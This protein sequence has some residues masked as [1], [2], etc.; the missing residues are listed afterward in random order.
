MDDD[1]RETTRVQFEM[2][3]RSMDR[4]RHLKDVTEASSY[5]EV[6]RDALRYYEFL[7]EQAEAGNEVIV[8]DRNDPSKRT[9]LV[10]P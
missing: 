6:F 2:P 3:R 9:V 5:A 1:E 7:I 4:L 10:R 8:Q